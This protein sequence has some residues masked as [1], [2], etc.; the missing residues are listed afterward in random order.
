MLHQEKNR[1]ML[2]LALGIVSLSM[3]IHLLHRVFHMFEDYLILNQMNIVPDHLQILLNLLFVIPIVL[4][5]ATVYIFFSKSRF[6]SYI[7]LLNTLTLTFASI[8]IIAGGN[9]MVEYHF[10]IFMV[11]AI[12]SYYE[13]IRLI[14]ISTIIF[15]MQHFLGYF[16]APE[17]ICGTADYHFGLLMIHAIF[18]ILT[19]SATI[20]QIFAKKKHTTRLEH[21]NA[22]KEKSLQQVLSNVAEASQR[23]INTSSTLSENVQKTTADNHRIIDTMHQVTTSTQQQSSATKESALVMNEMSIGIQRIAE[24]TNIISE[25]SQLTVQA[26]RDGELTVDSAVEQMNAIQQSVQEL[27]DTIAMLRERTD[28]IDQVVQ[29]IREISDQTNLLSLNATIEAARAGEHGDGFAVVANEVRKL[30]NQTQDSAKEITELIQTIHAGT[31]AT[32]G[33]MDVGIE[34]VGSGIEAVHKVGAAFQ[35]IVK[36]SERIAS[37]I[38]DL[39]ATAEQMS[40][41]GQQVSATVETVSSIAA[42]NESTTN[43]VAQS[44]NEQQSGIEQTSQAAETLMKLADELELLTKKFSQ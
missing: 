9:G 41:S 28:Q 25:Q 24:S 15:A 36:G 35:H 17:L 39:S 3:L 43:S 12:I 14:I 26:S 5:L 40:A 7:P 27:S 4:G 23:I 29:V 37:Q 8:S 2:I 22:A 38:A 11:L 16:F 10:S 1:L 20:L 31:D 6:T 32:V 30:A 18:L 34:S 19:S 33:A 21:E 44:I 13:S 42:S